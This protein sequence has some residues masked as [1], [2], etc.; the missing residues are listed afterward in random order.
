MSDLPIED[1]RHW[2]VAVNQEFTLRGWEDPDPTKPVLHFL[3]GNGFSGLTYSPFLRELQPAYSLF[4]ADLLG[5]GDSDAGRLFP[6][7]NG[8]AEQS[9]SVLS[10][11]VPEWEGRR[12]LG[13][14][15]SLGGVISVL[16]AARRP[17][18]FE[19]LV[20]MDPV[21]FSPMM[22][23][24]SRVAKFLGLYR[25][26]PLVR[27]TR[28]RKDHFPSLDAARASY[29]GRGVFKGWT[30]ECLESYLT[31]GLKR[32]SDGVTLKCPTWFEAEIF[33]SVPQGIWQALRGLRCPTH[34][35]VGEET[36][37]FIRA[38]AQRA[39]RCNPRIS[40]EVTAG[41]HCFMQ[42]DPKHAAQLVAGFLESDRAGSEG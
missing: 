6:G 32:G 24:A 20:L 28:A 2:A 29:R 9:L 34:I 37:A 36:D 17:E 1:F 12:V 40:V 21:L 8:M 18:I 41:R 14:G 15:H 30:D 10:R 5:H 23:R 42:E 38:S 27:R 39:A 4:I 7:W 19:R 26:H 25:W 22:L 3:H 35:I 16:M 13:V 11:R 33:A 31:H